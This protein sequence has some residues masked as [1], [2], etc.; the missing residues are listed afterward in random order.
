MISN[1]RAGC[2]KE[3]KG[4]GEI[5]DLGGPGAETELLWVVLHR[6]GHGAAPRLHRVEQRRPTEFGAADSE[7]GAA[8]LVPVGGVV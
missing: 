8:D 7:F 6:V 5:R 4:L 1:A 3:K 2:A